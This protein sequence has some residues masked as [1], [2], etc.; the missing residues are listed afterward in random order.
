MLPAWNGQPVSSTGHWVASQNMGKGYSSL[1][2]L[3]H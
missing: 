1:Y 2:G 3:G